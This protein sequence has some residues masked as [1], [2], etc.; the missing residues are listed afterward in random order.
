MRFLF[1]FFLKGKAAVFF[2]SFLCLLLTFSSRANRKA[3]LFSTNERRIT[4]SIHDAYVVQV[5]F[6]MMKRL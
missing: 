3:L 1:F 5:V 2:N 4:E 6:L